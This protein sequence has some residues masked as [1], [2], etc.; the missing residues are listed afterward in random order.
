MSVCHVL[1][2]LLFISAF[3]SSGMRTVNIWLAAATPRLEPQSRRPPGLQPG[4]A[5]GIYMQRRH[6][7]IDMLLKQLQPL[8][9]IKLGVTCFAIVTTKKTPIITTW[10]RGNNQSGGVRDEG[11]TLTSYGPFIFQNIEKLTDNGFGLVR[12]EASFCFGRNW[13][14]YP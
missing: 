11:T 8:Q 12:V 1:P 2:P 4:A 5:P 14:N 10:Q 7:V 3:I 13:R 6:I 9:I